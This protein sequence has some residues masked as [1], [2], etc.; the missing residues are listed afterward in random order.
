MIYKNQIQNTSG[1]DTDGL[2]EIVKRCAEH[3]GVDLRNRLTQY[4][5]HGDKPFRIKRS[6]DGRDTYRG[7]C[8]GYNIDGKPSPSKVAEIYIGVPRPQKYEEWETRETE[9]REFNKERFAEVV[10]HEIDHLL[11]LEHDEMMDSSDLSLPDLDDIRIR[12]REN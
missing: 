4:P 7:R 2:L 3:R 11:G 9:I 6:Q 8:Y 10:L 12:A 1:W 5:D